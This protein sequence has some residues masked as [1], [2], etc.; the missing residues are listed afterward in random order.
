VVDTT[1]AANANTPAMPS[2]IH[3]SPLPPTMLAELSLRYENP[4]RKIRAT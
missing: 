1:S 4:N 3:G 2:T